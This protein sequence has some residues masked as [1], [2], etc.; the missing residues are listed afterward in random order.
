MSK[1]V[2]G[3]AGDYQGKEVY[4]LLVEEGNHN[5][6]V[7]PEDSRLD[8]DR[9]VVVDI[10]LVDLVALEQPER[11]VEAVVVAERIRRNIKILLFFS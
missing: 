4:Q 9:P 6:A 8:L 5:Q 1:V 3:R 2:Q 7:E 10:Q 11:F